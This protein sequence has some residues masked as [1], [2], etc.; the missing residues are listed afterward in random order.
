MTRNKIYCRTNE[1]WRI[2]RSHSIGA[3]AIGTI[4]GVNP[5]ES[6]SHLAAKMRDELNGLFDYTQNR[7]MLRGHFYEDGVAKMFAYE[8]G[9]VLIQCSSAEY[10]VRRDDIPFMH[11]SP[12]RTYWL[13]FDG[14]T[15]GKFAE[16]NKG[17]LECKTTRRT[18]KSD[19]IPPYWYFQLQTQMG[20]LGYFQGALAWD[21]L[22]KTDGFDYQF[23][24]FNEKVFNAIVEVCDDFWHRCIIGNN[25]PLPASKIAR[26]FPILYTDIAAGSAI[27]LPKPSKIQTKQTLKPSN[28]QS[29]QTI[30]FYLPEPEDYNDDEPSFLSRIWNRIRK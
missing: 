15:H 29:Q 24:S 10:L 8:T 5:F 3:S 18:V 28:P 30:D 16:Q 7:A 14:P 4:L 19:H 23:Y 13:D 12:D 25:E 17:V 21:V 2:E 9:N 22:S 6:P 27:K 1:Q 26:K 11:A 20:I